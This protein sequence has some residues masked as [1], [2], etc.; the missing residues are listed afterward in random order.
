M[1]SECPLHRF[2]LLME[3]MSTFPGQIFP[4]RK[5]THTASCT[6]S[7]LSVDSSSAKLKYSELSMLFSYCENRSSKILLV[8]VESDCSFEICLIMSSFLLSSENSNSAQSINISLMNSPSVAGLF[9]F[10]VF[11]A[12]LNEAL[13][14]LSAW[15]TGHETQLAM[16][17]S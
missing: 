15:I 10:A 16:S 7:V 8:T 11:Q 14:M 1:Q 6:T 9:A 17:I 2:G 13:V 12:T 4:L 3:E 5:H